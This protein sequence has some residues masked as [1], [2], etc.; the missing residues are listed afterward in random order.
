M[1][2]IN[3]GERG[4]VESGDP[5]Q[6]WHS[7]LREAAANGTELDAGGRLVPCGV[8]R[9]VL[10]EASLEVDPKGL[11]LLNARFSEYLD[12]AYIDFHYPLHFINCAFESGVD[13]RAAKFR[14]LIFSGGRARDMVL[15]QA[16][17]SGTLFIG[18]GFRTSGE[19]FATE[20]N[21]AGLLNMK[22]AILS[23]PGGTVL[24]LDRAN[25]GGLYAEGGFQ[26]TGGIRAIEIRVDSY[27]NFTGARIDKPG[28]F[29]LS[30]DRASIRTNLLLG[31][32][33]TASGEIHAVGMKVGGRFILSGA[34]LR[35]PG[36]AVLNIDAAKVDGNMFA[37]DGFRAD[38]MV[39][40]M[41]TQI[42]GQLNLTNAILS[43]PG[44]TALMAERV[45]V[46]GDFIAV[47]MSTDGAIHLRGTQVYGTLSLAGA[48]LR[49]A[50]S[51]ALDL[52]MTTLRSGLIADSNFSI[53]GYARARFASIIG[54]LDL[55][56]ADISDSGE[57]ALNLELATVGHLK[58]A[59]LTTDSQIRLYRTTIGDVTTDDSPPAPLVATGWSIG[60]IHGPLRTSWKSALNWL[61]TAPKVETSVQPWHNVADI[62]E[63]NGDLPGARRV[64]FAAANRLT[65]RS[66]GFAKIARYTYGIVV[67]HGYYPL[68]AAGWLLASVTLGCFVVD[69]S[70]SDIVP[71]TPPVVSVAVGDTVMKSRSLGVT[72][73]TPCEYH[74]DLPCMGTLLFTINNLMP[75]AATNTTND[76][77]VRS[78]GTLWLT[79]F[80]PLLKIGTWIFAALLL[81]GLTGLLRKA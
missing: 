39:R 53:K 28:E 46:G 76:W 5:Q 24:D 81:A 51:L 34:A 54:Q 55:S 44:G 73:E 60:D 27:V 33:F 43:R 57:V 29:A 58:L 4:D 79:L 35:K 45:V 42:G 13:L 30:L 14:E 6:L 23:N 25:L 62:Y 12:L 61:E 56:D 72:A 10:V 63:K 80:L 22:G 49:S 64:R 16:A 52:D 70:K 19:I 66:R 3:R 77:V 11:H 74:P 21:V 68:L 47:G 40:A 15:D 50:G 69:S 41:G 17:I 37:D 67:G 59:G 48:S 2:N 18:N 9:E 7:R 20:L 75:P 26:A 32:G 38:G 71:R 36:C 8:V 31:D 78:D 1:T 65:L